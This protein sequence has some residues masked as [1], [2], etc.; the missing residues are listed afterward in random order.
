[1]SEMKIAPGPWRIERRYYVVDAHGENVCRV[2]ADPTAEANAK[3]IAAAPDLLILARLVARDNG[4]T[5]AGMRSDF[6]IAILA[7]LGLKD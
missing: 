6:A 1:M 3:L 2:V 4:P 7:G 5:A